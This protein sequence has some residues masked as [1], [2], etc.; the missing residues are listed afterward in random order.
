MYQCVI[1]VYRLLCK[2]SS[3]LR[4][5]SEV[6]VSTN[7][8]TVHRVPLEVEYRWPKVASVSHFK[9]SPTLTTE[10]TVSAAHTP[11]YALGT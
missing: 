3:L 9:F 2:I 1:Y 7:G 8:S 10:S 6:I 4:F 11:L 5:N